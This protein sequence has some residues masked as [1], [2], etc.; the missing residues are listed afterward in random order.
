VHAFPPFTEVCGGVDYDEFSWCDTFVGLNSRRCYLKLQRR[1]AKEP[2]DNKVTCGV[3]SRSV[4]VTDRHY[5]T[6]AAIVPQ[7][8]VHE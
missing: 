5:S 4:P 8:G 1:Y 7:G 6:E 3:S 2:D